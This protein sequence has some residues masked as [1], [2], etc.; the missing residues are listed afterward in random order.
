[1]LS[2]KV[3]SFFMYRCICNDIMFVFQNFTKTQFKKQISALSLWNKRRKMKVFN[4]T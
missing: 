2:A 4:L 1:M 3:W